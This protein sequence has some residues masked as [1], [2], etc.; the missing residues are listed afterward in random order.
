MKKV[1]LIGICG[2]A[3]A[4]LAAMLRH[5]DFEVRGSDQNVYPPMKDFLKAQGIK[6][7]TGYKAEQIT[8]DLD[9]V[10]IG[11]AVSRGNPEVEAVLECGIRYCSLPEVIRDQFLWQAKTLVFAGT[12]GKTSTASMAAWA[13]V[14]TGCDPSFM[15]G[16]I[17]RNFGAGCRMG[18]GGMFVIE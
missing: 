14:S 11:N 1:H 6:T 4:G 9:L 3:M 5:R 18:G 12:H 8:A 10:V 15:I 16:G 7:F 13:L 2:T 17:P